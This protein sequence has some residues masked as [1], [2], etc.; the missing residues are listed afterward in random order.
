MSVGASLEGDW[1]LSSEWDDEYP[2]NTT[3]RVA[4]E[5]KARHSHLK[6]GATFALPIAD[7]AAS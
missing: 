6:P 2:L 5:P 3:C 7:Y 4:G 1:A